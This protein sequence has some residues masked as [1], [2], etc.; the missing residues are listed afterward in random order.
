MEMY[1][2]R[3]KSLPTFVFFAG[4]ILRCVQ[5]SFVF[6]HAVGIGDLAAVELAGVMGLKLYRHAGGGIAA[7]T[8]DAPILAAIDVGLP[9]IG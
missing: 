1:R 6:L 7:S 2:K 3:R 8:G 4:V 5:R 9:L